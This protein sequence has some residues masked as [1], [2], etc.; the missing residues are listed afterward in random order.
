MAL[1]RSVLGC[2]LYQHV[3]DVVHRNVPSIRPS[4]V[5]T[6][7]QVVTTQPRDFL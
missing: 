3:D 6:G 1:K 5:T 4:E 2:F 7:E